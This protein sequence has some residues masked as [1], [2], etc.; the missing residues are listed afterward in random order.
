MADEYGITP[1]VLVAAAGIVAAVAIFVFGRRLASYPHK[2]H[3]HKTLIMS[4]AEPLLLE[5][6][7]PAERRGAFRRSGAQVA[8][9]LIVQEPTPQQYSGWV[10][11][12]SP[13]GLGIMLDEAIPVGTVV[14]VRTTKSVGITV[15]MVVRQSHQDNRSCFIGCE[16]KTRPST[17]V[18]WQFG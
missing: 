2:T 7:R 5:N 12:R 10:V 8:V 1:G 11:D 6:D 3:P 15:E 9:V 13:A 18:L 4:V 17:E 14:K 16:F